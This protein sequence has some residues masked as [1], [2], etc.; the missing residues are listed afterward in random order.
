MELARVQQGGPSSL[1]DPSSLSSLSRL[2][3]QLGQT[4]EGLS[5]VG[6]LIA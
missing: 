6:M 2:L 3:M 1:A 4:V 5:D